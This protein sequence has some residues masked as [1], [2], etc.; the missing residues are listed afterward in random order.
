MDFAVIRLAG[1]QYL[2]SPGSEITVVGSTDKIEVLLLSLGDK[3][4]VGAPLVE[5]A[6]IKTEVIFA[7]KGKKLHI[8]KF[9]AKSRYRRKMG[10][11]P[12]V[13]KLKI[14]S[15]DDQEIPVHLRKLSG[16]GKSG[17]GSGKPKGRGR[18]AKAN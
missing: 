5:K 16:A 11:R 2:V 1:K 12:N 15:I 18:P 7:G 14:L 17:I 3:I 10:F 9:K 8:F 6:K 13:T 4:T